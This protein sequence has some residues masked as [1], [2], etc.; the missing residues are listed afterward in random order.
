MLLAPAMLPY[1]PQPPP[2]HPS[3]K[4]LPRST[5]GHPS[6]VRI[7]ASPCPQSLGKNVPS[8]RAPLDF[9]L[10]PKGQ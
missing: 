6:R 9:V 7:A 3:H 4:L 2:L 8:E 5:I 10:G 1:C